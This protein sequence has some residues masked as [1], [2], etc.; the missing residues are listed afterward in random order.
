MKKFA[1]LAVGG[2]LGLSGCVSPTVS[3]VTPGEDA[4]KDWVSMPMEEGEKLAAMDLAV[5]WTLFEDEALSTLV[6][7]SVDSNLTLAAAAA[8][9]EESLALRG[10]AAGERLPQVNGGVGV[11]ANRLSD[12]S[13]GAVGDRDFVFS[14]VGLDA[15]WELDLWG[16]IQKTVDAADASAQASIEDFR[17]VRASIA[18]QVVVN[19]IRLREL[20]L[21]QKLAEEN[22]KLQKETMELTKGRFDAGLVPKLDVD[23]AA[24]NLAR[25]E[26]VLPQLRQLESETLRALEILSG[27]TP[28]S[29]VETL[30]TATVVPMPEGANLRD[31]PANIIRRRPDLRAAEQ[32]L[33]AAAAQVGVAKAT[34]YPRISL[35]GSFAWEARDGEDLFG[36]N[37][38]GYT[39]G[40][41]ILMPI[42]QGG[43]LRSQVDAA[44]ARALQAELVYRQQVLEALGEVENA[45]TAYQEEQIRYARLV[46]G[47]EA[48]K[49]TV[50]QVRSLYENGLVTFLNVLDAERNLAAI[51]DEAAASLGQTSR[52]LANVYRAFGGGWDAPEFE[53]PAEP[54]AEVVTTPLSS[55][56]ALLTLQETTDVAFVLK[57]ASYETYS[58][59]EPRATGMV[60]SILV[61]KDS[62]V[63]EVAAVLEKLLPGEQVRL[64]WEEIETASEGTV[65][66]AAVPSVAERVSSESK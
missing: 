26:A 35:S 47:V 6:Q 57:V 16:R 41:S 10:V 40:P 19:Y 13:G 60:S 17:G 22:I 45:L 61:S 46:E 11:L 36:S 42:F 63:P 51:E 9:V 44:E 52:N 28:G 15:S 38:V 59:I 3:P 14:T 62:L 39:F 49:S 5:W 66:V 8:R 56:T 43:R 2:V 48:S 24:L 30:A 64:T 21:R 18:S 27:Q 37:S 12:A 65:S 25:T 20:Q 34:L 58:R 1:T 54:A 32:Q 7:Q 50:T 23:Q 4:P 33:L 55:Q 29:L 53:A 31:L